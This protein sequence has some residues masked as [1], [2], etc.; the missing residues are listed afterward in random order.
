MRE[1]C[2]PAGVV[3]NVVAQPAS[4]RV[5][6]N[7]LNYGNTPVNNIKIDLRQKYR[8]VMLMSPDLSHETPVT[9]H[10]QSSGSGQISAPSLKIYSMLV[11]NQ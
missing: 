3:Y 9:I 7:L 1:N 5:I 8:S 11:L 10:Q 4:R 2:A 6:V